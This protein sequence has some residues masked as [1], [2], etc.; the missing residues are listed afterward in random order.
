MQIGPHL[1]HA[2]P[3]AHDFICCDSPHHASTSHTTGGFSVGSARPGSAAST[4]ATTP[5]VPT[6][7]STP[8]LMYHPQPHQAH[9]QA[10]PHSS[11][12]HRPHSHV[13]P[14]PAPSLGGTTDP[15][16]PTCDLDAFCCTDAF[17]DVSC[18]SE[19][20]GDQCCAD[21]SCPTDGDDALVKWAC[22]KEGCHAI[23]QYVSD[24][25][26]LETV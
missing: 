26:R 18:P 6:P 4:P 3:W 16:D 13:G 14:A 8:N 25:T 21:P 7:T 15:C 12:A 22:S 19:E 24:G 10:H 9:S 5:F 23:Q 17:C 20:C 1:S 11:H 2:Q